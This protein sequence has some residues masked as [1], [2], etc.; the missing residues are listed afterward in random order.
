MTDTQSI[1]DV[2]NTISSLNINEERNTL[3]L[4]NASFKENVKKLSQVEKTKTK[5]GGMIY[6]LYGQKI[7]EQSIVIK[8]GKQGE[9]YLKLFIKNNQ[10]LNLLPCGIIELKN[11]KKKKDFDLIWKDDRIKTIYYREAKSNINFDTE[12]L[13]ATIEKIKLCQEDLKS[14]YPEYKI[15]VGLVNWSIYDITDTNAKNS[16]I[17][18]KQNNI[19]VDFFSDFLELTEIKW[20]KEEFYQ[21]WRSLGNILTLNNS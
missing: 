7:S 9:E 4:I 13:P 5:P 10:N 1:D 21:Y 18:F 12:K 11:S 16:L 17:K 8:M 2:I 14:K 15:N 19:K 3:E 20:T 6:L